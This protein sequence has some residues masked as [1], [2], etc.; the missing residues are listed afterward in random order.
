MKKLMLFVILLLCNSLV[1]SQTKKEEREEKREQKKAERERY[2]VLQ[3]QRENLIIEIN[4]QK[5]QIVLYAS[6]SND[7]KDVYSAMYQVVS[8]EYNTIQKES[9]SRGY[10]EAYQE[11]DLNKEN[12]NAEIKGK[13]G[14][15]KVSFISKGQD[16]KKNKET[17]VYSEWTNYSGSEAYYIRLQTKLYN[18][19][20]GDVP[21]T[22]DLMMRIEN[23]NKDCE[24]VNLDLVKGKDY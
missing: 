1:F 18:Q 10:I 13:D 3:I 12:M 21:L 19:L 20:K 23:F 8:S 6:Y 7:F 16:R 14:A 22:K 2:R 5:K 9:E 11:S 15:Y 4:A 24:W 17:G